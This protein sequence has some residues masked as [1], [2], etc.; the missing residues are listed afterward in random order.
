MKIKVSFSKL[1]APSSLPTIHC[2]PLLA[3]SY[4]LLVLG[5]LL[6][7]LGL[8][9]YAQEK[10]NAE[11]KLAVGLYNDGMY[12]LAAEQL[13]NFINAYP[14]TS[15][16][17]EARFYLG[18]TQMKLKRYDEARITFQNF[19]LAYIEHPK[20]PAAWMNVGDAFLALKNEGEAAA[21]YERV[22]VF[23]PKSQLVP[24]ALH[25]AGQLYRQI[26]NRENAKKNFR[27]IVQEYPASLSVLPARLAIGEMY[28]EEG[29]TELAE[30][31]ARRVAESD[32]PAAVKASALFSIG[33][34]QVMMSLFDDAEKT[35]KSVVANYNKTPAAIASTFELGKLEM[36]VRN[37]D[38]AI[39][40]FKLVFSNDAG[41]DSLRAEA[42]FETGRAYAN[43]KE[44]SNAQKSFDKFISQFPKSS[45]AEPA[46]FE[47]GWAALKNE[48]NKSALQY[49]KKLIA[50]HNSQFKAQA[51]IL[52]ADAS[53]GLRQYAEAIRYYTNFFDT[54]VENPIT[55]IIM[56][57]LAHLYED[58]LQDYRKALNNYDQIVQ[59]Y[60][61]SP[62]IVDAIIG[63]ARCQE[64]TGDYEGAS[65]TYTDLLYQYPACDQF[66]D[67]KQKVEFIKHHKIKNPDA[68]IE[69]LARLMGEVLTEKSKAKLS[70]KLGA[71]Y[72]NDLKDYESAAS[73]FSNAIEGGLNEDDL[74]DAFYFRARAYHLQS[75][76]DPDL[77][78]KAINE[79]D[80]FLKQFP[81]SKWTEDASYFSYILKSQQK[82]STEIISL[83]REFLS[84]Y[85]N[86]PHRDK[87]LFDLA[88]ATTRAG[89]PADALKWFALITKEFPDSP[90]V[91][92]TLLEQ[93]NVYLLLRQQ[94]SA[95]I[96][97]K[98]AISYPAQDPSTITAIWNL[99][100]LQRQNDNYA[101]AI[102]LL[103]RITSEFFYSSFAEKAISLLPEL[104]IANN[105]YDQA[106]QVYNDMLDEQRSS[107]LQKEIDVNLYFHLAVGHDKKGERQKAVY[108]YNQY[109]L[110]DRRGAYTS[111]AFYALGAIARAQGKLEN[112]SAYFKQ[113][114][115][116]G[117]IGS[118]S[119]DIADLLFQTEQY[120]EAA[121][122]Y[123]ELA[124]S[125]DSVS[126]KQLYLARGIVATFRM[127]NLLET[128]KLITDFEKTFKKEKNYFA[129]FEY[130][131]GLVYYR[132]QDY[133]K[134]KK[135]FENVTDDYD[136]TRFGPWG[137]YYIGKISEVT[138]KLEEA[139]KKYESILK[140]YPKSDV[141]PRAL[142]SLGNMHFN[143]ERFEDAIRYYQQIIKLA[144]TAGDILSYALNNL[145]EAY[146]STK[147]YDEALKANRDYIERYPNDANIIDKKIKL[148][149]LF[150][151][152]GYY[153][154]AVLHLQNLLPEAGSL[155]EAEIRYNIGEAF[156]YKGDYQQA[157]LEFLKVPYLVTKQ[158]K[159]NWTATAL[160]MA[161]QSYEKMSKFDEAIGMYQQVIDRPGIDATF[162]AAARKEIDRVKSII[163]NN[164]K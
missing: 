145:I 52:A 92:N 140:K 132:K 53:I 64:N 151:K 160:Y 4:W 62:Q 21:A 128:Q 147:M 103:K 150:I 119:K 112:A 8:P 158:G 58:K 31:E 121:K 82:S 42:I 43:Q 142:L 79:Y 113:A 25:K 129:E 48:D 114:A 93:G 85:P 101:E 90:L 135:S 74:I 36:G 39:D 54:H 133:T 108:Y 155:L 120:R 89:A 10:E 104:Y 55:P 23:H 57:K 7:V 122:Q 131:K 38:A 152:I 98:K 106:I 107:P 24:E 80:E 32:A 71:I 100:D 99:T 139:A 77:T 33:K 16:G 51:L 117:E 69:K 161:G 12:D 96:V 1:F 49:A 102:A 81:K 22:K 95:A 26:G 56:L 153:D 59:R 17:I 126:S 65:K 2:S 111:K 13:K 83:A 73:Q 3:L 6:L 94:D 11:F 30:R 15:N 76:L 28:A 87:V 138:N 91:S 66:D 124:Q 46:L 41:G 37:Y 125:T 18:E 44:Y 88:T 84:S 75:E 97:W 156:Y 159:I 127:D 136:D 163:K 137:H 143:A 144:E 35:F 162:K 14:T 19:A 61:Q 118:T 148:G 109:L 130:E 116:L 115:A 68:G 60:T 154:Q 164:P 9:L 45:L 70:L 27:T 146:E 50:I 134:A 47:A 20:A 5:S 40:N 123:F 29:Q 34:L 110:D 141:V 105:E 78:G 63:I 86:S 157:I 67:I 149:T 72:F